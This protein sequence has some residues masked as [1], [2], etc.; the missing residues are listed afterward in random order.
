[1]LL[2]NASRSEVNLI[3]REYWLSALQINNNISR[4]TMS[5]LFTMRP[6]GVVSK[7]L[8][9]ACI[10]ACK[11]IRNSVVSELFYSWTVNSSVITESFPVASEFILDVT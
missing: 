7:K 10:V 6:T 5:D 4:L 1:M 8:R 2:S 3:R 9:G 11:W